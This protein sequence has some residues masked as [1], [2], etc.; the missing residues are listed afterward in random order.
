M[1]STRFFLTY[2]IWK[3]PIQRKW[4][5]SQC[6]TQTHKFNAQLKQAN[7]YTTFILGVALKTNLI[8]WDKWKWHESLNINRKW[9]IHF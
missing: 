1:I 3:Y 7:V 9:G 4:R 6:T 2:Y 8:Q 5:K